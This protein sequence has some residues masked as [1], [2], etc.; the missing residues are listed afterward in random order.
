MYNEL[1]S[2]LGKVS[3]SDDKYVVNPLRQQFL[4]L[5]QI[6]MSKLNISKTHKR[7]L[8][9]SSYI[10]LPSFHTLYYKAKSWPC[11]PEA[12]ITTVD[13]WCYSFYNSLWCVDKFIK[14]LSYKDRTTTRSQC[15]APPL[16]HKALMLASADRV[17]PPITT[18]GG[19][20]MTS[21]LIS[22]VMHAKF[23][24]ENI[25]R[26]TWSTVFSWI[27]QFCFCFAS[28]TES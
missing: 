16:L 9:G 13:V 10:L 24:R 3:L 21:F 5:G 12:R 11:W 4:H 15:R 28:W 8:R 18:C 25:L 17:Q 7:L 23:Y 26:T 19:K 27:S 20:C 1:K 22:V 2:R 6:L 14:C